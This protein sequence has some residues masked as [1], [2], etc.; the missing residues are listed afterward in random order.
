MIVVAL[1]ERQQQILDWI[2]EYV[3]LNQIP[4]TRAEVAEAFGFNVTA[5]DQ[6]IRAIAAKGGLQ[7]I[8]KVSRGIVLP[9][10]AA[11]P[12]TRAR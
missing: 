4:P 10:P 2:R 12:R 1:T 6:H 3:A 5:A 7:L 9:P 8:A 11:T